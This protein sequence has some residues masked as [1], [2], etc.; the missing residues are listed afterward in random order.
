[1]E[2]DEA[3]F[4]YSMAVCCLVHKA[5]TQKPEVCLCITAGACCVCKQ[6]LNTMLPSLIYTLLKC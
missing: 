1:M 5:S 6:S 4:V 3:N 2:I